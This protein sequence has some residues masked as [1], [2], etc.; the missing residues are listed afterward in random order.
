MN[1]VKLEK[2]VK[3]Q[4]PDF[5]GEVQSL[6]IEQMD[7]RLAQLAKA[8][9]AVEDQKEQDLELERA[10]ELVANIMEPYREVRKTIRLKTKYLVALINNMEDSDNGIV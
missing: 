3:E 7:N 8:L 1:N 4:L 2:K 5:H 10:R 6:S 9:E